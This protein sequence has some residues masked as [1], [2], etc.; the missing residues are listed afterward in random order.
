M[1]A[2]K[3]SVNEIGIEAIN[4]QG[5]Y[6]A[7]L[8]PALQKLKPGLAQYCQTHANDDVFWESIETKARKHTHAQKLRMMGLFR[9]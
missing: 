2:L 6:W 8:A 1:S 9:H 7:S 4:M 5:N 3:G